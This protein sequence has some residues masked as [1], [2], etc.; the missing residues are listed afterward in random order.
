M[1]R[2]ARILTTD[3][4]PSFRALS[5]NA[6]SPTLWRHLPA[7]IAVLADKVNDLY[8]QPTAEDLIALKDAVPQENLLE[9]EPRYAW[10]DVPIL[11]RGQTEWVFLE[12]SRPGR[13]RA[14][15]RVAR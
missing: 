12:D 13:H 15:R 14:D 1:G 10:C 3:L 9:G 8:G 6:N 7:D 5:A 11:D 2:R 4:N